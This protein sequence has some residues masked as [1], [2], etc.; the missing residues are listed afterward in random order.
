MIERGR[1]EER[2]GKKLTKR[3]RENAYLRNA[4]PGTIFSGQKQEAIIYL[5]HSPN[6][7]L[8]HEI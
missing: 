1:E 5:L 8:C 6:L 7:L 4:L 3:E 2:E